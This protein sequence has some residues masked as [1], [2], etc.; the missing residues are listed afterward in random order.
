M[1]YHGENLKVFLY[2]INLKKLLL[3]SD[4]ELGNADQT[5]VDVES[6]GSSMALSSVS[7]EDFANMV[8]SQL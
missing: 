6:I 5:A 1:T 7:H 4:Q 3:F 2:K 8:E